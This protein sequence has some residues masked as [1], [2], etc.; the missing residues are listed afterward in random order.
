MRNGWFLWCNFFLL[1]AV[2]HR[3]LPC[4]PDVIVIN[5][6]FKLVIPLFTIIAGYSWGTLLRKTG[7]IGLW[8]GLKFFVYPYLFWL[9]AY[10]LYNN[11]LI[12][13][14]IWHH[15]YHA[16]SALKVLG[17][18]VDGQ[19]AG[20]LYYIVALIYAMTAT[21]VLYMFSKGKRIFYHVTGL[22]SVVAVI[23]HACI[24]SRVCGRFYNPV[25][26]VFCLKI[27]WAVPTF[28][29]GIVFS[30]F[31]QKEFTSLSI[32]RMLPFLWIIGI[33]LLMPDGINCVLYGGIRTDVYST[34][35]LACTIL[36]TML[37][38][39]ISVVPRWVKASAPYIMGIYLV[40]GLFTFGVGKVMLPKI[41]Y[42]TIVFPYDWMVSIVI[43]VF[44]WVLVWL[45][46]RIPMLRAF[47]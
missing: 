9:V 37:A 35:V 27:C 32:K 36:T 19:T 5:R 12:E 47:V 21:L 41:G 4:A 25:V 2:V 6:L 26:E 7:G 20:F 3:H 42:E 28:L 18:I 8:G 43:V 33:V 44:S 22:A 45:M 34:Y 17:L 30:A 10:Y 23:V 40:H 46:R 1:F 15:Q 11:V 13:A 31:N 14:L 29:A 39:P 38:F 16:P 24:T